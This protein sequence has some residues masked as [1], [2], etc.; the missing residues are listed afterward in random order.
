MSLI[1]SIETATDVC[2]VSVSE[3]N[4][5]LSIRETAEQKSHASILTT[6]IS[7]C[8]KEAGTTLD[9][10]DA[11]AVSKGPG[12]Y[13]GLRIGVA[14]AKGI[15][16]GCDKPLIPVGTLPAMVAYRLKQNP[17][18]Q[19]IQVPMI[20][21]RRMEVYTAAFD[22]ELNNLME[23]NAVILDAQSFQQLET[24]HN[25]LLLFG[26]GV[27]KAQPL[28]ENFSSYSFDTE[29]LPSSIGVAMLATQ[30]LKNQAFADIA[31]F[32]PFYL[33]DFVAPKSAKT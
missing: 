17:A 16:F 6:F 28:Y 31:Y 9:K 4:S 18:D 14:T 1:L 32:E 5:I 21:A 30:L 7:E 3:D 25:G 2:S 24:Q 20:D 15:C 11:V 22:H 27:I 19:R 13:T 8:I 33:K 26:D 23:I 12:S 29:T 10:L